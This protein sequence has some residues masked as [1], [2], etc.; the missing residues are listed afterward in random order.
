MSIPVIAFFNNKGGVGKTTLVYHI[1]WA[2]ADLGRSVLA[3]DLDPQ[4]NLTASFLDD[5]QLEEFW[6]DE[7]HK[8]TVYGYVEPLKRRA[9]Y[10]ENPY[11]VEI[12]QR[13]HL[14]PGDL[15]LSR[16]EDLLSQ[17]WPKCLDKDEGA[18]RVI[19]AFWR[20]MQ[21]GAIEVGAQL[22]IIDLGPNLGAINRS[23]LVAADYLVVPLTPDLFSLRGLKNIGPTIL[24]WRKEWKDRRSRNPV[25]D[26][27]L[28]RGSIEP[29]GYIIMQH[30]VRSD[31]PVKAYERWVKR[32]PQV[33]YE[34]VVGGIK[35]SEYI[36]KEPDPN[37][38]GLVK[39]YRSLMPMS[40]EVH[41]PMFH[42]LPAD[43]AIGA[44]YHAVQEAEKNFKQLA[45][46]IEKRYKE[47]EKKV[48]PDS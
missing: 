3:A 40:M 9:G 27:K 36:Y 47:K 1:S 7:S 5:D 37:C 43:G 41:K 45:K 31:R 30:S 13:L 42:L 15:D 2:L 8:K 33:Y 34:E 4:A 17:E 46:E 10:I 11:T 22:I 32:I 14:L 48:S 26:L 38:L 16:F 28:P 20:M 6:L 18:F 24:D 12:D 19:S 21:N 44:H 23:A 25:K 39:H 35:N 29:L